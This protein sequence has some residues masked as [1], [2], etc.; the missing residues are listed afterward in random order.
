MVRTFRAQGHAKGHHRQTQ[1]GRRGGA[2]RSS[3]A[4]LA[5]LGEEVFPREQRSPEALGAL[6]KADAEKWWPTIK[7]LGIKAE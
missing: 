4:I 2:G 1:R 5:D 7:E 6:V 3:G